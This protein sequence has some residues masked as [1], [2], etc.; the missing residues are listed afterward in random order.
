MFNLC[1]DEG[2][3]EVVNSHF[4]ICGQIKI[5]SFSWGYHIPPPLLQVTNGSKK[6]TFCSFPLK[7]KAK[8]AEGSSYI[9][10]YASVKYII[11]QH[12]LILTCARIS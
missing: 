1:H 9:D 5:D 3:S 6:E 12:S 4:V 7:T 8:Y 11:A 10:I 2:S